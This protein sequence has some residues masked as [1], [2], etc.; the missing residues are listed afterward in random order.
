MRSHL[1]FRPFAFHIVRV[2]VLLA[3]FGVANMLDAA[4]V[5]GR[6]LYLNG[7]P[8]SGVAVRLSNAKGGSPFSYSGRNGMYYL[9]GIP[10]GAYTLEVWQNRAI[11][12]KQSITVN[13]PAFDAPVIKIP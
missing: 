6:V 8:A 5:R 7:S 9:N 10:A 2:L 3:A 12:S 4:A 13:E 1:S 11:V